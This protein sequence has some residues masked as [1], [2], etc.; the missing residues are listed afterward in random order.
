V[1]RI[2]YKSATDVPAIA[3]VLAK[4][5]KSEILAIARGRCHRHRRSYLQHFGCYRR[6]HP[7][8]TKLV[9]PAPDRIGFLD[10]ECSNLKSDFGVVLTWCI[11]DS[12]TG[13]IFEDYLR[14]GDIRRGI[15][16]ARIVR[17]LI[18]CMKRFDLIVSFYG[19]RFDVPF[20]RGRSFAHKI[21]FPP[22]GS[23]KHKDLYFLIRS[24]FS[25]LSSRGLENSTRQLLGKTSKTRLDA[26]FWRDGLRGNPKAIRY[27]LDH[28]R[29]DVIDTERLYHAT[30]RFQRTANTSI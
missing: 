30:I 1:P 6:E 26:K 10:I 3:T 7:N 17:S 11:K 14:P 16:D 13:K 18:T 22:Y 25:T 24:K 9:V 4:L 29:A 12:V 27:I 23:I 20:I 15:E 5:K 19:S 8:D 28:N 2:P 21:P